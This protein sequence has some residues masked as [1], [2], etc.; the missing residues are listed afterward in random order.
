MTELP[1]RSEIYIGP[2]TDS[3]IWDRF[4][5]RQDDVVLS[6]PPKC[7]TTWS[8]AILMML[9]LGR[10]VKDRPV[11]RE[12]HWLDCAFRNQ[13]EA[14]EALD[15]QTHRRCIKSHTPLDGIAYDPR[16][17]YITVYRHPVDAHFSMEKHVSNMNSDILDFMFPEKPGAAFHRFLTAPCASAG[18]DD[19]SVASIVHHYLSFARWAHLPNV[20]F[21]HYADLTAD[22]SGQIRRYADV[23]GLAPDDAL[24]R[25]I[26]GACRFSAMKNVTRHY[27]RTK[28]K[29]AFHDESKFF[30]SATSRKWKGRLTDVEISRYDKRI[31]ELATLPDIEWLEGGNHATA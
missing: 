2:A 24:S 8:Q 22:L 4:S 30:D 14:M 20:H 19:L 15:A 31:R 13:D 11:W 10:A 29:G 27:P 5:F 21:F 23:L 7:G 9:L 18:T 1:E 6:T 16:V 17:T 26:A 25:E 12:S 28:G 3:R